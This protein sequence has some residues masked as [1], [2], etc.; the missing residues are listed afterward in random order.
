MARNNNN[1]VTSR[2]GMFGTVNHYN[3]KGQK[4]G[5]SRPGFFGTTN[6]YD[7]KGRK[8]GSSTTGAFGRSVHYDAKGHR[9]GTSYSGA[10]S[11][12]HYDAKGNFPGSTH[13]GGFGT[14]HSNLS[15]EQDYNKITVDRREGYHYSQESN[16]C[17]NGQA[18][19]DDTATQT[20]PAANAWAGL[21]AGVFLWRCLVIILWWFAI[22][23]TV[24]N[25]AL[26]FVIGGCDILGI[27]VCG[28]ASVLLYFYVRSWR[29]K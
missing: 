14:K 17:S 20:M 25:I 18:T 8:T 13:K 15:S 16:D 10:F 5:E 29:R 7:A 11:T 27:L 19:Y 6:H 21:P 9:T 22:F 4:I 26:A 1:K 28:T 3:A 23:I 24:L 12:N 2:P